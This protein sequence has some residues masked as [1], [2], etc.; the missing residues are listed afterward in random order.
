[1]FN[2]ETHG[3]IE[4]TILKDLK[5][6]GIIM[7]M[8]S[9]ERLQTLSDWNCMPWYKKLFTNRRKFLRERERHYKSLRPHIMIPIP[10]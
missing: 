10:R 6:G 1:V 3:L 5:T 2:L 8:Y 4:D 9:A 7:N